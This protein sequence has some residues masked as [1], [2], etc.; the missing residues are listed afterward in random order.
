MA[1]AYHIAPNNHNGRNII[2]FSHMMIIHANFDLA[3]CLRDEMKRL[4]VAGTAMAGLHVQFLA[5]VPSAA[6]R[7]NFGRGRYKARSTHPVWRT[8]LTRHRFS[9]IL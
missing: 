7:V 6:K 1:L 3:Y 9:I 5:D 4:A 8:I 2:M